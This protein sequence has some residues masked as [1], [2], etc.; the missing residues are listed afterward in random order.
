MEAI[1][2]L[3]SKLLGFI[4]KVFNKKDVVNKLLNETEK[5][6]IN[7]V[8]YGFLANKGYWE[9]WK[10][11]EP[12]DNDRFPLPWVTYSFIDFIENRLNKNM[13]LFEFGSGNSTLYYS[14]RVK[15]VYT[16]ENDLSWYNKIRSTLPNNVKIKYLE[17][18]VGGDYCSSVICSERNY[19]III[20][21]G[22]D[23]ENSLLNAAKGVKENGVII[24]DDSERKEYRNS[25]SELKKL[26]YR[27]ID[28][29]GISPGFMAYNKCTSVYYKEHNVLGI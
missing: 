13:R 18:E 11:K 14:K 28:F 22:G 7:Y 6:A 23:R 1:D 24:L 8:N 26:G 10:K 12:L 16:V 2:Y 9:S 19:D 17:L 25:I 15:E 4:L 5:E 27:N 21:D 3:K 20:V 29:W